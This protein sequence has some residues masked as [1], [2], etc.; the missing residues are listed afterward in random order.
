MGSILPSFY[1]Q[2]LRQHINAQFT[3]TQCRAYSVK[4]GRN[5]KFNALCAQCTLLVKLKIIFCVKHCVP[6]ICTLRQC[7]G[8]IDPR[9]LLLLFS[10]FQRYR[11]CFRQK[12][13]QFISHKLNPFQPQNV[14]FQLIGLI[15]FPL[16]FQIRF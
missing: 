6:H 12:T 8:E 10:I 1:E 11:C 9:N 14:N 15:F 13:N 2:L 16:K 3:G 7:V 5:F 4:I